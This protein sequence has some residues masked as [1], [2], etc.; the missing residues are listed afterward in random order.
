LALSSFSPLPSSISWA[1]HSVAL[2]TE[3]S[4]LLP[5]YESRNKRH[6]SVKCNVQLGD[7]NEFSRR[8]MSTFPSQTLGPWCDPHTVVLPLHTPGSS[9]HF[10]VSDTRSCNTHKP[11]P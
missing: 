9:P 10:A 8:A 6:S 3:I 7:R 5:R 4:A 2:S 11:L 1:F